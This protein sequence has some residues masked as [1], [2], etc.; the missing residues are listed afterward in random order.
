MWSVCFTAQMA[1]T[2]PS[3]GSRLKI[4]HRVQT[5]MSGGE[6]PCLP[7][8]LT[9]DLDDTLWPTK[10]VIKAAND[11]LLEHLDS[12][13]VET[14]AASI[15]N[16]MKILRTMSDEPLTYRKQRTL[17][18]EQEMQYQMIKEGMDSSN[19][20]LV[21]EFDDEADVHYQGWLHAR[22]V[23]A[24]EC[25]Y[26]DVVP[27]L[28][29]IRRSHGKALIVGAVTNGCG[30]P[31]ETR[32]LA[33]LFDFCVSA[34]DADVF[35]ERKP[36]RRPF[37]KALAYAAQIVRVG[38][39][40]SSSGAGS[41]GDEMRD[42][43]STSASATRPSATEAP[44]PPAPPTPV[45]WIHVGKDLRQDVAASTAAG[46]AAVWVRPDGFS[47][48]TA[49]TSAFYRETFSAEQLEEKRR[50]CEVALEAADATIDGIV[51]LP[52]AVAA[53]L[54]AQRDEI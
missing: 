1:F 2:L 6:P 50:A 41:P 18:I 7:L 27:A 46:A 19:L 26:R 40:G 39:A 24:S 49:F 30:D 33:P 21:A 10:P 23:A 9:F 4:S 3:G 36:S 17:A 28:E 52:A 31:L 47:I 22:H 34:E 13:G 43:K 38:G 16:R 45:T 51:E 14:T 12:A 25:L 42:D 44:P 37:D 5:L 48:D 35:P 8:L 20:G 53:I 54:A 15:R 11:A 32:A 29:S